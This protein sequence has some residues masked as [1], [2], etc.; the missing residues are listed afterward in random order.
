MALEQ[1][2]NC[3]DAERA[4]TVHRLQAATEQDARYVSPVGVGGRAWPK[5]RTPASDWV[6]KA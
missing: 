3:C 2:A 6:G 4:T 5:S 1:D